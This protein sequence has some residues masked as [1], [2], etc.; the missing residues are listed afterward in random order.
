MKNIVEI[1]VIQDIM[2]SEMKHNLKMLKI[3]FS[4]LNN[5]FRGIK[6]LISDGDFLIF[7]GV[8]IKS[9]HVKDRKIYIL[10]I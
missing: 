7:I 10:N 2:N 6:P 4:L 8:F 3:L 9:E 1:N 5:Y